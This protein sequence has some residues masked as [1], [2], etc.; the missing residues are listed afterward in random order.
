MKVRRYIILR[1]GP[2]AKYDSGEKVS[3]AEKSITI[4]DTV[5]YSGLQAGKTYTMK[6]KLIDKRPENRLWWM[7]K[8][9][10]RQRPS[11]QINHQEKSS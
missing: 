2:P 10:S 6:G 7:E 8:K 4:E 9:L 3:K 5:K 1:S 11:R